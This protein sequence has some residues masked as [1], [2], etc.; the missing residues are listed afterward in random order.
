MTKLKAKFILDKT[1]T[2]SIFVLIS[3]FS[4]RCSVRIYT[5]NDKGIL[6]LIVCESCQLVSC[7]DS[8]FDL[9]VC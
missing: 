3:V 4:V 6:D 7:R 2:L 9:L 5:K 8:P 1:G